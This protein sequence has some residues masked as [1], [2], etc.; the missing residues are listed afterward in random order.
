M[1]MPS[2]QTKKILGSE[3]GAVLVVGLMILVVLSLLGITAMQTITVEEKMANNMSQRYL[4]FQAAEAALVEAESRLLAGT[5]PQAAFLAP[6][7]PPLWEGGNWWNIAGSQAAQAISGL[8]TAR[9]PR[10]IVERVAD[11]SDGI[12]SVDLYNPTPAKAVFRITVRAVGMVDGAEV[13]LQ[14]VHRQ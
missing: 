3:N 13:V 10:Y 12:E 7:D 9:A 8:P 1:S 6:S 2:F 5:I 11:S 4:A 14:S